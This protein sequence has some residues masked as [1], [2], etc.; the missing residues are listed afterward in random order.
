ME[1]FEELNQ[2]NAKFDNVSGV[3]INNPNRMSYLLF[4]GSNKNENGEDLNPDLTYTIDLIFSLIHDYSVGN[5]KKIPFKTIAYLS[6]AI[7]Y[8][9][10]PKQTFLDNV[11][12]VKLIKKIGLL[13]L[14]IK[15]FRNDLIKY[16]DWRNNQEILEV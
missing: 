13:Q 9:V 6:S 7:I 5:Y 12:G 16:E 10:Y 15:S 11:P 2:K 8:F 1:L 14:V 4:H 3:F